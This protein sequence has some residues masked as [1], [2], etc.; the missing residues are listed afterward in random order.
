MDNNTSIEEKK[1]TIETTYILKADDGKILRNKIDGIE[2]PSVWLKIGDSKDD[3]E[4]VELPKEEE[5][6]NEEPLEESG[7]SAL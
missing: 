4:E 1:M 2:T 5:L 7:D 3:W 6:P